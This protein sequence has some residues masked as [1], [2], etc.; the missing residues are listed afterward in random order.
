MRLVWTEKGQEHWQKRFPKRA[1]E[2]IA[3]KDAYVMGDR[4]VY[5]D[6]SE[7][8]A[9]SLLDRCYVKKVY[10]KGEEEERAR[11]IRSH[12]VPCARLTEEQVQERASFIEDCLNDGY[13]MKGIAEKLGLTSNALGQWYKKYKEKQRRYAEA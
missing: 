10:E 1:N 8:L 4:V 11:D 7:S 12:Y 3:G 5:S 6:N 2:R 9:Q 13:T